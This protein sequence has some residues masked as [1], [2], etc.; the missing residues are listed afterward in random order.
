MFSKGLIKFLSNSKRSVYPWMVL[1]FLI[2]VFTML[3]KSLGEYD[4][5]G[6]E[7]LW[8]PFITASSIMSILL[9]SLGINK[10]V[11]SVVG[12]AIFMLIVSFGY[13]YGATI[14]TNCVFDKSEPTKVKTTVISKYIHQG[15]STD[16]YLTL[17]PW[18]AGQKPKEI[19]VSHSFFERSSQGNE[20][21]VNLKKG[22]FN[23][24]WFYITQ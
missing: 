3:I 13:G 16:Y 7:H 15:K 12:Q 18:E 22:T 2:P 9:I 11:E 20:V 4:L 14:Q 6:Y 1:G 5:S 8:L 23:I 17:T 21:Q 24:P 19:E 10:T